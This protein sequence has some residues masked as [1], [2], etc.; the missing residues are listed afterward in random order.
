MFYFS[1]SLYRRKK[2]EW[3]VFD[4]KRILFLTISI[5]NVSIKN[6]ILYILTIKTGD[7]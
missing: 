5:L 3:V 4:L 1:S 7:Y 6:V 2:L